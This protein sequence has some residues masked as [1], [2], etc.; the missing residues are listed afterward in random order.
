[1]RDLSDEGERILE[2][3]GPTVESIKRCKNDMRQFQ[4]QLFDLNTLLKQVD[5]R[6]HPQLFKSYGYIQECAECRSSALAACQTA[7]QFLDQAMINLM[8]IQ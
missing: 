2:R 3:L 7:D 1:M 5:A 4:D 8:R 6:A